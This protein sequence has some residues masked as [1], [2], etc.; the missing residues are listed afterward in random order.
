MYSYITR[1]SDRFKKK[2]EMVNTTKNVQSTGG[3]A[4]GMIG[5]GVGIAST[6][7]GAL[8][9]NQR[10]QEQQRNQ[11]ELMELQTRN[12]MRLN[13]H[14][15]ELAKENWDYTNAENQVQHY[16]NA[17]LNVGLMYGSGGGPGG[18]LS[19]G[20]GGSASSGNAV[21]A[22]NPGIMGIQLAQLQSQVE[23]NKAMANKANAE[24]TKTYRI[25]KQNTNKCRNR[26]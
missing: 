23:L 22:E 26:K 12:Q 9:S 24:A 5:Q 18:Q 3:N 15:S 21:M 20:S 25:Y 11:K 17:G 4:L 14:G 2:R 7:Y 8:T 13:E 10:Q 6:I 1:R 19:S 16:K